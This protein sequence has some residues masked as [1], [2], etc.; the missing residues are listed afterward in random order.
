MTT[1]NYE[2]KT[3]IASLWEHGFDT[4]SIHNEKGQLEYFVEY[5]S[6]S[7]KSYQEPL[8][9]TLKALRIFLGY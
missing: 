1:Y 9:K 8:P 6:S 4:F 2:T 3:I 7:G 5:I